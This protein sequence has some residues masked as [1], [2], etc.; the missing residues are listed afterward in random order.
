ML[1]RATVWMFSFSVQVKGSEGALN[2]DG[3]YLPPGPET[4]SRGSAI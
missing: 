3:D 1:Q 2:D 4:R